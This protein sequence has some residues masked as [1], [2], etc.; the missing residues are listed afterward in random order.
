MAFSAV[1]LVPLA[2][3]ALRSSQLA[4]RFIQNNP[5]AA[6]DVF[7]TI[8][9]TDALPPVHR[10]ALAIDVL[11][12]VDPNT[13]NAL[14]TRHGLSP[15]TIERLMEGGRTSLK[16]LAEIL[17]EC[18]GCV[19]KDFPAAAP[20]GWMLNDRAAEI[21][22]RGGNM[23]R[24]NALPPPPR[25][26]TDVRFYDSRAGDKGIEVKTGFVNLTGNVKRQVEKD[27]KMLSR[28]E[29]S[30]KGIEWHFFA[31][32]GERAIGKNGSNSIGGS[33]PLIEAL[34][35]CNIKYF[36]HMP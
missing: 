9:S 7:R 21:H 16:N 36:F 35:K 20:N 5:E 4:V 26:P 8:A 13:L 28:G 10:Q 30:V 31:S 6:T 33:K 2:G 29:P 22:M 1:G 17:D 25:K 18:G 3:D 34:K 24:P 32:D 12:K 14:T 15:N 11:K 23:E 27:C 19:R